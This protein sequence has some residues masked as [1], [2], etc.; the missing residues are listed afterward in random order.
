MSISIPTSGKPNRSFIPF[1]AAAI[2]LR[3]F[4]NASL[5]VSLGH[6]SIHTKGMAEGFTAIAPSTASARTFS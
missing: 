4:G 3:N 2:I 1:A 6:V 5:A